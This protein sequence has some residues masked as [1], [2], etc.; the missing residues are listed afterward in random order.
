MSEAL[1]KRTVSP[2]IPNVEIISDA[3]DRARAALVLADTAAALERHRLA[4]GHAPASLADLVPTFLPAIPVDP[5]TD[6]PIGYRI[7]DG[8]WTLWSGTD[9]EDDAVDDLVIR[10]RS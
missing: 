4:T 7:A 1:S 3:D 9:P 6:A 10:D 8:R 2:L 5:L